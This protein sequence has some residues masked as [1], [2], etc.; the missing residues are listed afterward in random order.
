MTI[1]SFVQNVTQATVAQAQNTFS[2]RGV[3]LTAIL[4]VLTTG[5]VQFLA[6]QALQ[7]EHTYWAKYVQS[8]NI[9]LWDEYLML[10]SKNCDGK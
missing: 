2:V 10:L 8:T 7:A 4:T 9:K 6:S 1:Q 3:I 5:T